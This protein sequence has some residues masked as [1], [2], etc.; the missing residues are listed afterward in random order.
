MKKL[1]ETN[2]D[3]EGGRKMVDIRDLIFLNPKRTKP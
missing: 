2:G 1:K 3:S